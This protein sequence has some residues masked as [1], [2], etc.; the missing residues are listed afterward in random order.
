MSSV[1]GCL[2]N[3]VGLDDVG[4]KELLFLA[5]L[6]CFCAVPH[7][8]QLTDDLRINSPSLWPNELF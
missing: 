2:V 1:G 7:R 4:G 6:V 3:M 8:N 5:V